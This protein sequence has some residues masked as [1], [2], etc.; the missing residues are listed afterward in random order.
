MNRKFNRIPIGLSIIIICILIVTGCTTK[1]VLDNQTITSTSP[2]ASPTTQPSKAL[3]K[4][5]I[6]QPNSTHPEF[7]KMD[8]DVYNQGEVIEFYL[9]NEGSEKLA[10]ANTPPSFGIY[11][12]LNYSWEFL[13]EQ[14]ETVA[15]GFSHLEPGESTRVRRI[16]T[17]TWTPGRYKI[18]SDC[19]ISR[20]FELRRIEK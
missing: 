1:P 9:I 16:I 14:V 2:I 20:E 6:V 15:P 12:Q 11:H 3:Y 19:G 13:T 18:V 7:I 17:T 10:C 4:V 5:T 8:A